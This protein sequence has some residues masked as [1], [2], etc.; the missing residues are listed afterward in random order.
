MG[1]CST[2]FPISWGKRLA[3]DTGSNGL[4]KIIRLHR[5]FPFFSTLF[6]ARVLGNQFLALARSTRNSSKHFYTIPEQRFP[7]RVT[8]CWFWLRKLPDVPWE[9]RSMF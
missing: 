6:P 5:R 1:S 4:A 9:V 8:S 7:Q 3:P 2:F